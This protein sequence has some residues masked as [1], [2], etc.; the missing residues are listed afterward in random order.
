MKPKDKA[1]ELVEKH[2]KIVSKGY[3]SAGL[4]LLSDVF[5]ETAKEHSI[6]TCNE[7]LGDMGSDRGWLFWDKIRGEIEKL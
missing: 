7:I 2:Y 1:K 4:E 6:I 3:T 5:Y